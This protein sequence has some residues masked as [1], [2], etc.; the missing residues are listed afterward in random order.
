MAGKYER[1][2]E[3][4]GISRKQLTA[5]VCTVLALVISIAVLQ[6]SHGNSANDISM[7]D[8][9]SNSSINEVSVNVAKNESSSK[10]TSTSAGTPL[11][12]DAT[13]SV[14][15]AGIDV[16][17][18]IVQD[19]KDLIDDIQED[20][21][22]DRKRAQSYEQPW[23]E[24]ADKTDTLLTTLSDYQPDDLLSD[25]W[26]SLML[27]IKDLNYVSHS[28]SNWDTNNDGLYLADEMTDLVRGCIEII[29]GSD[30]YVYA[31]ED[32]IQAY[33]Q[34][35][36]TTSNESTTVHGGQNASN[37]NQSKKETKNSTSTSNQYKVTTA[38]HKC[39]ECGKTATRS[40][41]GISGQTEYYCTSCYNEMAELIN[42]L[43]NGS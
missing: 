13:M 14:I 4:K 24:W 35:T 38:S 1:K 23:K 36:A 40:I 22:F 31:I 42:K 28:L 5:L 9:V 26:E 41:V 2:R 8:S 34:K 30:K 33:S 29:K 11:T 27:L 32:G 18:D 21:N 15:S 25:A 37:N 16:V 3:R 12:A 17:K 10:Q 7:A 6:F 39:L 20:S 43:F 19:F